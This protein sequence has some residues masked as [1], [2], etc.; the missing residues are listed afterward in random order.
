MENGKNKS[1]IFALIDCNNFFVSCQRVFDP[2]LEGKP[3]VVLSSNDGVV[4]ARSNEAK[5]IGIP[6]G[7]PAF[8][9]RQMFRQYRVIQFSANFE[10]YGDISRRITQ[11]LTTI[12]PKIEVYS[13][14]ES[15]LDLSE[16]EIKDYE[17]WGKTVRSMVL[18]WVGVPVSIGIAP[19]KTLA[20]LA[21]ERT[22][23]EPSLGG[24]LNLNVKGQSFHKHLSNTPVEDVWGVG[25]RLAP[26]LRA[27][28]LS[29]AFDLSKISP[30]LGRKLIGSVHGDQLVREL[31]GQSCLPLEPPESVRKS[32]ARTRTFGED[33]TDFAV[34]EA[35]IANFATQAAFR[36]RRE[37]LLTKKAALFISS[38]RNKPN[39]RRLSAEADLAVPTADTGILIAALVNKL[40]TIF[41]PR[42]E[43]HRAGVLLSDFIP[44]S[45]VQTDFF[46]VLNPKKHGRST[47]RM[48]AVDE[49]NARYG[50]SR[51]HFAAEDLGNKWEPKHSLRSPRYTSHWDEL[52][53]VKIK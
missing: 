1:P 47:K 33:T 51:I 14:D 41:D 15:F 5:A 34:L 48:Q 40:K 50:K 16:L 9:Y 49:V 44:A 43:Y 11:L 20:K 22:K 10:I 18:K 30:A 52:P 28:G 13:V 8:K 24:A 46:G 35:A 17:A 25:R 39:Y 7:A 38:N 31:N 36:L 21:T 26:K 32:V 19:T 53:I 4:V 27:A 12:T 3:V 37:D 6:M 23:K 45:A 2:S 29:T 42:V